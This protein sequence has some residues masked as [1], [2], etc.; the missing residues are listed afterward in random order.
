MCAFPDLEDV[1]PLDRVKFMQYG[2]MGV[3]NGEDIWIR[4]SH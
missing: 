3:E 4:D 2:C 1:R